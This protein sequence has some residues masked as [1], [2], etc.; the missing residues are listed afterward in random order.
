MIYALNIS[1]RYI[2]KNNK[3]EDK[4]E[5]LENQIIYYKL[6]QQMVKKFIEYALEENEASATIKKEFI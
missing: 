1:I 3:Y 2:T 5:L 6:P 4:I